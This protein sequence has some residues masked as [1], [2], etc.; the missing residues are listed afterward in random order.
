[1]KKLSKNDNKNLKKNIHPS[2][3]NLFNKDDEYSI[4]IFLKPN[5]KNQSNIIA[6]KSSYSS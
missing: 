1:M 3:I 2:L 4:G 6:A 5:V